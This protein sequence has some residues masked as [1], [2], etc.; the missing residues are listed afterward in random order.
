MRRIKLWALSLG[1][2]G[3]MVVGT[4]VA[5]AGWGWNSHIE[6]EGVDVRT[7]CL[8]SGVGARPSIPVIDLPS[9]FVRRQAVRQALP[10]HVRLVVLQVV[11]WTLCTLRDLKNYQWAYSASYFTDIHQSLVI[12]A[13]RRS[14]RLQQV[15]PIVVERFE[16]S[17][18]RWLGS[19]LKTAVQAQQLARRMNKAVGAL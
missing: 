10:A 16:C 11:V 3:V 19:P 7:Q 6:V 14:H 13:R 12:P 17:A 18:S 9:K 8:G 4:S 1:I 15:Q 5:F 2:L